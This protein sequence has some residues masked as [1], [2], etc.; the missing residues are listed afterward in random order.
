M[1][2][3]NLPKSFYPIP[4]SCSNFSNFDKDNIKVEVIKKVKPY[5]ENP[6]FDPKVME[7]VSKA[8]NG[9]CKWVRAMYVYD[10]VAKI[11]EPK[12][13]ELKAAKESL[14]LMMDALASSKATLQAVQDRVAE[15]RRKLQEAV[16]EKENLA[17]QV[18]KCGKQLAR[19]EK[20]IGGLGGERVRWAEAVVSLTTRCENVCGDV[21][22]SS[23]VVAYLGIFTGSF[24]DD[25]IS[26]WIQDLKKMKIPCSDTVSLSAVLGDPVKIRTWNI[27]GLPRDAVSIDNGIIMSY[28]RR[29]PLM[30]DPQGQANTWITNTAKDKQMKFLK[31]SQS[32]FVRSLENAVQ[33]GM[34]ALLERF[35]KQSTAF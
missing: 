15:L 30:I 6:D 3:G 7:K 23:A 32:D 4:H 1:T 24:R 20:L 26:Q 31:L 12:R 19:A 22:I 18:D 29:W 28:S 34:P 8:A 16:D 11:V 25:A 13:I 33:F 27:N 2:I 10:E 9:L 5:I 14:K 17:F 35:Q 21:L